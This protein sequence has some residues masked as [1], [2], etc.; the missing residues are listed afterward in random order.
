MSEQQNDPDSI[1]K[2]SVGWGTI[3]GLVLIL[4]LIGGVVLFAFSPSGR[5]LL[6]ANPIDRT[7]VP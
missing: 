6:P 3:F 7:L 2:E 5:M 1:R 4:F